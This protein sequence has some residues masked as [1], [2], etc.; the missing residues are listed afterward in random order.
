MIVLLWIIFKLVVLL[1]IMDSS[2]V[3]GLH[4]CADITCCYL[5]SDLFIFIRMIWS[6]NNFL[7]QTPNF[8]VGV[9]TAESSGCVKK[10]ITV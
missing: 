4:A 9:L 7:N 5:S 6:T 3:L 2:D 8:F 10:G 1:L